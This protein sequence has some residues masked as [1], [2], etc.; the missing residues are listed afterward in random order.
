MYAICCV[1]DPLDRDYGA[2]ASVISQATRRLTGK[3]SSRDIEGKVED[4]QE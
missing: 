1:L 4:E 2:V 3:S